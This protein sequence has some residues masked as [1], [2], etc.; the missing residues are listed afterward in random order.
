[1]LA[2]RR[3][4]IVWRR[5]VTFDTPQAY[6]SYLRRYPNGPHA[7]DA[8]RRLAILRAAL[9]PPPQFAF[10]DFGVPPPP[11]AELVFID[12]PV[13]IF[14]GPGL[15]A[16]PAAARYFP[17]AAPARICRAAASAAAG[18]SLRSAD[19]E[20]GGRSGLRKT[21]ARG[22]GAAG[23]GRSRWPTRARPRVPVSLPKCRAASARH[24]RC[25][26]AGD[27]RAAAVRRAGR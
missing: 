20:G 17:A 27:S 19:A 7:W 10:V 9:D 4:E 8:R 2:V 6:W 26:R 15:G 18:R 21:A 12:Q 14:A 3:E 25:C 16:A 5:C 24:S 22:R 23:P 11:P 1:M 13:L